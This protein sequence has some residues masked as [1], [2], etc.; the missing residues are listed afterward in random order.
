[1]KQ[2][3][4]KLFEL[5]VKS[6]SGTGINSCITGNKKRFKEG[7]KLFLQAVKEFAGKERMDK[8]IQDNEDILTKSK[9]T[10]AGKYTLNQHVG[11]H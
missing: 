2:D 4:Q 7:R 8:M 9:F 6:W 3:N 10:G 5:L 1:M 11:S